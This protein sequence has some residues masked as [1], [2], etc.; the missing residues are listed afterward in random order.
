MEKDSNVNRDVEIS[1]L[2][3]ISI[4]ISKKRIIIIITAIGMFLGL[5][6]SII[7]LIQLPDK[8]I[9]PNTYTPK[10]LMLINDNS[11]SGGSLSSLI[12][13][14]GLGSLASL[15][16]LNTF[17]GSKYSA[18]AVYL[19]ETNEFLDAIVDKFSLIDR[20]KIKKNPRTVSRKI[21][22]KS[23]IAEFDESTGVLT[24]SFTD[25]DPVFAQSV[26]N[27]AVS[28]MENRF[29]EMGLDKNKLSKEN[30][31]VNLKNSYN[32]IVRLQQES[33]RIMG[34]V[35]S[36]HMLPSGSSVM[37]ETNRLE[38]ELNAQKSVY[39]QLK[40]QYEL[41]KVQL[42]SETPVFQVLEYAEVPDQ[43]SGPSRGKL[44]IIITFASFFFSIFLVFFIH[45]I[46]N[47]RKDPEAMAK[48]K[49]NREIK[50]IK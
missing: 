35:N 38:M 11:S 47:I 43:K 36:G 37:L 32:E 50:V 31:E 8:S 25:R 4:L 19:T 48:L 15:A 39:T 40:T 28:N 46:E 18:L 29:T 13:S 24:I 21:L 41:V 42:A 20:Y 14:S 30:L 5:M 27:F 17:G 16:G 49:N 12:S 7:S 33:Q 23:L 2:N 34:S 3:L 6:I 1:L 45:A 22:K 9:L 10:A 44:C 26:V